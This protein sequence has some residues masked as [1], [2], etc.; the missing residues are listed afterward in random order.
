[1]PVEFE[2]GREFDALQPVSGQG[3]QPREA[4][5]KVRATLIVDYGMDF[6]DSSS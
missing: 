5:G 4:R 2:G 6:V 1:M 3:G